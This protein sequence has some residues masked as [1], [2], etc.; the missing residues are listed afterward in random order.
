MIML[1]IEIEKTLRIGAESHDVLERMMNLIDTWSGGEDEFVHFYE[2]Q[3]LCFQRTSPPFAYW[4]IDCY[5][6]DRF[7]P[8]PFTAEGKPVR[9]GWLYWLKNAPHLT[10]TATDLPA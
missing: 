5:A 3:S 7:G 1:R 10:V 4:R 2:P 6:L 8:L 9:W